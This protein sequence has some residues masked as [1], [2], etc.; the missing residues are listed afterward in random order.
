MSHRK[1]GKHR[2]ALDKAEKLASELKP[3]R[4]PVRRTD[5]PEMWN[6]TTNPV[7][8]HAPKPDPKPEEQ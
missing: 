2:A 8:V 7:Q 1:Q 4:G 6:P 5:K 3:V